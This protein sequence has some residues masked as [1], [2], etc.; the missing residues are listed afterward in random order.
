MNMNLPTKEKIQ[1][2]TPHKVIDKLQK[3]NI[4]NI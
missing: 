4:N 3:K 2:V 1:K